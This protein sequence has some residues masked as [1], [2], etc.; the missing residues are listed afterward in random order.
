MIKQI[1]HLKHFEALFIRAGRS[2]RLNCTPAVKKKKKK[3]S[4]HTA[5][6]GPNTPNIM[7]QNTTARLLRL[8]GAQQLMNPKE[9]RV[10]LR[11]SLLF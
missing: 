3:T 10:K 9:T 2:F 4:S 11:A 5:D 7:T 8:K 6:S 1:F